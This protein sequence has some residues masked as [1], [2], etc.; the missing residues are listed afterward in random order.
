MKNKMKN[1]MM[2]LVVVNKVVDMAIRTSKMSNQVCPLL[3]GKPK[4]KFDL[5]YDDY[6]ALVVFMKEK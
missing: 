1:K 6:E 4:S 2:K 5:T 3:F